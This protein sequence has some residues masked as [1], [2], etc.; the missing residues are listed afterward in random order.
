M[1]KI[2]VFCSFSST[3]LCVNRGCV[4]EGICMLLHYETTI[5]QGFHLRCIP[6]G[7]SC[8]WTDTKTKSRHVQRLASLRRGRATSGSI[9]NNR[10]RSFHMSK[11]HTFQDVLDHIISLPQHYLIFKTTTDITLTYLTQSFVAGRWGRRNQKATTSWTLCFSMKCLV[12][13]RWI[14]TWSFL[15]AQTVNIPAFG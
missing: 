8:G 2:M 10:G 13:L 6:K 12:L 15:C 7:S 14:L 4:L 3:A 5:R 1:S 11:H 9:S